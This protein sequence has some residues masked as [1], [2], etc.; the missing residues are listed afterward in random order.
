MDFVHL[1]GRVE[2]AEGAGGLRDE[3]SVVEEVPDKFF[4]VA[5]C[6]MDY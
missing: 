3:E 2:C 1:K 5:I 4:W 6:K